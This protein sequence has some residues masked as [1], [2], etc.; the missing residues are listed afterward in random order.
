MTKPGETGRFTFSLRGPVV[1]APE[2]LTEHFGLVEEGVSWFPAAAALTIDV[3]VSPAAVPA[4]DPNESTEG[5]VTPTAPGMMGA[6]GGCS[7]GGDGAGGRA[8]GVA[9]L[10]VAVTLFVRRRAS[11]PSGACRASV[12]SSSSSSSRSR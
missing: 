2:A 10:F 12:G 8:T 9:L 4:G 11:Y 5:G 6:H 7:L 3:M 1:T